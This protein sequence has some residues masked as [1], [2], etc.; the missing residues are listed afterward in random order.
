MKMFPF[1][2]VSDKQLSERDNEIRILNNDR[3]RTFEKKYDELNKKYESVILQDNDM[4]NLPK[5]KL[6]CKLMK[7]KIQIQ[8]KQMLMM[9]GMKLMK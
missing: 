2:K 9:F 4:V 8:N 3:L 1:T 5:N 6:L 7:K